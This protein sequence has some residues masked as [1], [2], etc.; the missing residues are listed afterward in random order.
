[1]LIDAEAGIACCLPQLKKL[2]ALWRENLPSEIL[3]FAIKKAFL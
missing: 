1:L 2:A 3:Q